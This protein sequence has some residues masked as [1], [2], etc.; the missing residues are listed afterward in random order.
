[1]DGDQ[2]G[3]AARGVPEARMQT[4]AVRVFSWLDGRHAVR[5]VQ[6]LQPDGRVEGRLTSTKAVA[7]GIGANVVTIAVWALTLIPGWAEIPDE[8]KAAIVAL[9]ASGIGAAIV[10]YAPANKET[11]E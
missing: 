7:A 2:S 10:Y 11:V 4:E 9:V 5:A 8:P 6:V 3:D 1:M